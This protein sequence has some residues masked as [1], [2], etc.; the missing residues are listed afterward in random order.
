MHIKKLLRKLG[1]KSLT[2]LKFLFGLIIYYMILALAPII[3]ISY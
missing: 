2:D 3:V 1:I